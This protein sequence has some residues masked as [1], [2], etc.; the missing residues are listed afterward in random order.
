MQPLEFANRAS[1]SVSSSQARTILKKGQSFFLW[2]DDPV[3]SHYILK[4]H[5]RGSSFMIVLHLSP[6]VQ[7]QS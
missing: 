6:D 3:H 4:L 7:T 5:K 2:G 1:L